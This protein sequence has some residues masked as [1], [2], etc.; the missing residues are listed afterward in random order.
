MKTGLASGIA[1]LLAVYPFIV[2]ATL[3]HLGS[4]GLALILMLLLLARYILV[5]QRGGELIVACVASL[6]CLLAAWQNNEQLLRFYPVLISLGM[7]AI[8]LHSLRTDVP[9]IERLAKLLEQDISPVAKSYMRKLTLVWGFVLLLNAAVAY[10][11]V[12]AGRDVW[13]LYNGL[14][15]YLLMGSFFAAELLFRQFYRRRH[16]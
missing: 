12:F 1:V 4:R 2:L 11:T 16:G 8:F 15:S 6:C 3:E 7:A 5:K 9:V 14:I 10:A 13:A